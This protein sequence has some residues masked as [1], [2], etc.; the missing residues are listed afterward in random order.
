MNLLLLFFAFLFFACSD[1]SSSK[2]EDDFQQDLSEISHSKDNDHEGFIK[3]EA[4]GHYTILG[5]NDNSEPPNERPKMKV[6]FTYDFSVSDHEVTQQEYVS[7]MGGAI[8]EGFQN[9]AVANIT[10]WD[11]VLYAN[12]K[13]KSENLDTC[14]LYSTVKYDASHHAISLENFSFLPEVSGYRMLTEAEW[15]L[16]A[17]QDWNPQNGWNNTNSNYTMHEVCTNG[18]NAYDICDIVGNAMEWV[19]DWKISFKDTIISNFVGASNG[20]TLNE[21]VVKGGSF[22]NA[23]DAT[24]LHSRGDIYIV[25]ASTKSDYVGGRLAI[26]AIPDAVWINSSGKTSSS[27]IY[28]TATSATIKKLLGTTK[29]KLVFRND[30]SGNLTILNYANGTSEYVEIANS[31]DAYHPEISPDGNYVAFCTK[32]EGVAGVSELYVQNLSKKEASPIKL[33]VESAAIP[34]W[35][36]TDK[37]DTSIIYVTDA[38]SNKEDASFTAQSTWQVAFSNN[39]FGAPHKLFDGA[40][41]GGIDSKERIAVTGARLLRSRIADSS[42]TITESAHDTI[43][44]NGEQACNVSLAKDGSNRTLFLDFAGKTGTDFVGKKYSTHERLL[45]VDNSGNLIQSVGSPQGYTFDHTEWASNYRFDT[46]NLIIAALTNINGMHSS[47]ALIDLSDSSVTELVR[48]EEL[49]HP[50]LWISPKIS[51]LDENGLDEDSVCVYMTENSIIAT[52]LMK[53][54]MDFFWEYRDTAEVV[55]IG[56]SRSFAGFDP[57]YVS[58]YFTINM[59]YSAEDLTATEYFVNNYII[60]LM[61]KLKVVAITLDYDRWYVKDENWNEWFGNIPGYRYDENH[62]FWEDG[63]PANMAEIS[64]AAASPNEAEYSQYAYHNGLYRSDSEGY[65][66][67]P[68]VANDSLW[69]QYDQSGYEYN[70]EK[71]KEI[72]DFAQKRKI[73]IVGIIYPQAPGFSKTGAWGRYGPRHSDAAFMDSVVHTLTQEYKNFT[74]MDEYNQGDNVYKFEDF[75]NSDHLGLKGAIKLAGRFDSLLQTLK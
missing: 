40:Y 58:T 4:K 59:A 11:M 14:Y 15:V 66:E 26:G 32:P 18:K 13:S 43:W 51:T 37:G 28:S 19:N 6:N 72:L 36:V 17:A 38:G 68:E 24:K 42:S 55:V 39:K 2:G 21:G 49:W 65:E 74:V 35:H 16:V 45:V 12:A 34:R 23:P 47:I 25:T 33:E 63:V 3:I 70:L 8:E 57:T 60:P 69:F 61:P 1:P 41:H 52:Q 7:L 48:G 44:Y 73:Q 46:N 22:R 30:E 64:K 62:D 67:K 54:K 31:I 56:S 53:V 27:Q 29:A 75:S 9:V 71:L 5:T 50:N 20:G 10:F